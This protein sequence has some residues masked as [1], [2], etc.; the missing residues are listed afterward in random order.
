MVP[1]L[2]IHYYIASRRL[3]LNKTTKRSQLEVHIRC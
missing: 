3:G 2:S 1:R